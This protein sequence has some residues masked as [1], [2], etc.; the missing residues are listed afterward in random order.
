MN[1]TLRRLL[2]S[3][4]A[5]TCCI[6]PAALAQQPLTA[7][8]TVTPEQP[9]LGASIALMATSTGSGLTPI[10]N[11]WDLDGDGQFDDATGRTA[12]TRFETGGT[13]VIRLRA[14]QAVDGV[15]RTSVAEKTFVL[16]ESSPTPTPTATPDATPEATPTAAPPAANQ[17]PVADFDPQ[18]SR[19]G[20]LRLCALSFAYQSTPKTISAALSKDPDGQI[21]GYEW[22]LDGDGTFEHSTGAAPTVTHDFAP[23]SSGRIAAPKKEWQVSVR[24]T[25]DQGAQ[26]TDSFTIKIKPPKCETQVKVGAFT[27]TGDCLRD[28]GDHH[29][30]TEPITLNGIA[31]EPRDGHWV[32]LAANRIASRAQPSR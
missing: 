25:D 28:Y 11:D 9:A 6:A 13:R 30:S 27:A 31:I 26:A 7:S 5:A 23:Q 22:D 10:T 15:I 32:S 29:K 8:F 21:V 3:T 18:C 1:S 16:D 12:K 24:V 17:P 14:S 2:L 19:T 4:V 20:R